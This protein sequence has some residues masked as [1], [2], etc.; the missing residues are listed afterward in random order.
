M[1]NQ[2]VQNIIRLKQILQNISY[3][4]NINT[5]LKNTFYVNTNTFKVIRLK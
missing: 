2:T 1:F 4:A 5:F 3:V